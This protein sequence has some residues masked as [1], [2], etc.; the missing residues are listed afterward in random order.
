MFFFFNILP[1]C[2]YTNTSG[3]SARHSVVWQKSE[4]LTQL[5]KCGLKLQESQPQNKMC[6]HAASSA[7]KYSLPLP[8]PV[9]NTRHHRRPPRGLHQPVHH[10]QDTGC[11]YMRTC[12]FISGLTTHKPKNCRTFPLQASIHPQC[13]SSSHVMQMK[14]MWCCC[15][16]E[17]WLR[18]PKKCLEG[19]EAR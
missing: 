1:L 15:V 5:W 11:N 19:N 17:A 12:E 3:L 7:A 18:H 16:K 2:Q 13:D 6:V 8:E 9:P 4:N 14:L 10:L